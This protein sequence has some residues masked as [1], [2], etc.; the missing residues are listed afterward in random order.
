MGLCHPGPG[1]G[2]E[3]PV[4]TAVKADLLLAFLGSKTSV[5]SLAARETSELRYDCGFM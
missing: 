1:E 3:F 2:S 5:S 4:F